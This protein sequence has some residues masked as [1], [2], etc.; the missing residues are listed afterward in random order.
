MIKTGILGGTFDPFHYGHLHI[1]KAALNQFDL[2]ELWVMPNGR[3]PHKESSSITATVDERLE[4]LKDVVKSEDRFYL[5][6]YEAERE[7]VSYSFETME[8]FRSVYP[9]RDFYFIIGGDSLDMLRTWYHPERLLK[10]CKILVAVRNE[11]SF[12][13]TQRQID[14]LSEEYVS[15]IH[16]LPV[17]EFSVSSSEIRMWIQKG[18]SDGELRRYMPQSVI[19]YIR[20][21]RLYIHP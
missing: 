10:C 2:D 6:T 15:D 20:S 7:E 17:P 21:H 16:L 19:D 5:C 9:D 18:A 14:V 11:K 1:G 13:D 8:H 3:P 4:M 12:A